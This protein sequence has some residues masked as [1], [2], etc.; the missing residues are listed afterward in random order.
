MYRPVDWVRHFPRTRI[1]VAVATLALLVLPGA[2]FAHDASPSIAGIQPHQIG[3][4]LVAD[5]VVP[6]PASGTTTATY[7]VTINNAA[8]ALTKATLDLF[9]CN[10][11]HSLALGQGADFL[12]VRDP[13]TGILTK[14][15]GVWTPPLGVGTTFT[16]SYTAQGLWDGREMWLYLDGGDQTS[17]G[18]VEAIGCFIPSGPAPEPAPII[19]IPVPIIEPVVAPAVD[20]PA[21]A[22]PAI[23]PPAQVVLGA[24]IARGSAHLVGATGCAA[25]PFTAR[26]RGKRMSS[27]KFT[28]DGKAIKRSSRYT[29]RIDPRDLEVGVHRLIANVRFSSK[30]SPTTK[31]LR[32]SFQRCGKRLIAPRFTG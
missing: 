30:T 1:S 29:T 27:V 6:D 18:L 19:E 26:V 23:P 3:P 5:T 11:P 13:G 31:R 10:P 2:S 12:T 16:F 20:P 15:S 24:R 25:S 21:P 32:M 17:R 8:P 7:V 4:Y 22:A 28:L 9:I 14:Y